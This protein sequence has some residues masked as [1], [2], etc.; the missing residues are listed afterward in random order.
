MSVEPAGLAL[1][2]DIGQSRFLVHTPHYPEA[3]LLRRGIEVVAFGIARKQLDFEARVQPELF[4]FV[5]MQ[6]PGGI[7]KPDF[8]LDDVGQNP[9]PG[10]PFV[11]DMF[12]AH[13][14][15]NMHTALQRGTQIDGIGVCRV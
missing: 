4:G 15:R 5:F 13:D 1:T 9:T 3:R 7:A 11:V 10:L 6:K 8:L 2:A 12:A 14:N